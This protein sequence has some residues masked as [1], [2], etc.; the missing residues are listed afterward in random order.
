MT[1]QVSGGQRPNPND[2][3]NAGLVIGGLIVVAVIV[4]QCSSRR[5]SSTQA[6]R[7]VDTN[8]GASIA[9]QSP[10]PAPASLDTVSVNR[11]VAH[12]RLAFG[13]EGFS[14]AMIYSQN[15]YDALG[16]QFSWAQLDRCGAFDVLAARSIEATEPA[17][18]TTETDY[19][20]SE[21]VAGRYLAAATGAGQEAGAADNRLANLQR[22]VG[23]RRLVGAPST[24]D[25]ANATAA[26]DAD[27]L[28]DIDDAGIS[29]DETDLGDGNRLD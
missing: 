2:A 18:L 6:A 14:G 19:F 23:S 9:A 3:R 20:Q 28:V 17:D 24:P 15:C 4:G 11:G 1:R 22:L 5:D 16:R 8:M 13:A 26:L 10:P 7:M 29:M 21:A 27:N 25:T 12:M